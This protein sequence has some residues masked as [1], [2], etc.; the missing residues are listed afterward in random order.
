[1][2]ERGDG[3]TTVCGVV[4]MGGCG[5]NAS[6]GQPGRLGVGCGW[7][8]GAPESWQATLKTDDLLLLA[9][10]LCILCGSF[11]SGYISCSTQNNQDCQSDVAQ[12]ELPFLGSVSD[13]E[14]LQEEYAGEG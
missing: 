7:W 12:P 5:V 14:D 10:L 11:C 3:R 1:M 9:A 13:L 8:G 4:V 6:A 2:G